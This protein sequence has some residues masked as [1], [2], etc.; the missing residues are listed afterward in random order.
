[1]CCVCRCCCSYC[2]HFNSSLPGSPWSRLLCVCVCVCF[3]FFFRRSQHTQWRDSGCEWHQPNKSYT[4]T[5]P[6][7]VRHHLMLVP[8]TYTLPGTRYTWFDDRFLTPV[9]TLP[10]TVVYQ[11][12]YGARKRYI[13]SNNTILLSPR[14]SCGYPRMLVYIYLVWY[15][16]VG[17]GVGIPPCWDFEF[18]CKN[19]KDQQ[20]LLRARLAWVVGA[21]R[22]EWT[23]E[24][25]LSFSRH[26]NARHEP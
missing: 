26:I 21:I 9:R 14:W 23:R 17:P 10:Y 20:L 19:K 7:I 4:T 12:Q 5:L 11:V 25:G 3:F 18:I 2:Y 15:N 16:I 1:M 6:A 22:R 24:E 13:C 8:G